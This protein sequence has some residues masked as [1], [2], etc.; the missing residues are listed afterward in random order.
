MGRIRLVCWFF[1]AWATMTWWSRP[2]A[3][4]AVTIRI[5]MATADV[6]A[7]PPVLKLL[8]R[9]KQDDALTEACNKVRDYMSSR[10]D[11]WSFACQTTQPPSSTRRA[12]NEIVLTLEYRPPGASYLN[13]LLPDRCDPTREVEWLKPGGTSAN[14]DPTG[15]IDTAESLAEKASRLIEENRRP[16]RQCLKDTAPLATSARWQQDEA[17]PIIE[18]PWEQDIATRLRTSLFVVE[19]ERQDRE[20]EVARLPVQGRGAVPAEHPNRVRGR[21]VETATTSPVTDHVRRS[22]LRSVYLCDDT[23]NS[24]DFGDCDK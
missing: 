8:G 2:V 1:L 16:L 12:E 19:S 23:S 4:A 13:F 20:G 3:M 14:V 18:M 9:K 21:V 10:F 22:R 15:V 5:A 17:D 24:V 6:K 11:Y 7:V